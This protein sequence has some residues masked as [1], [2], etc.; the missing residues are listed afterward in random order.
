MTKSSRKD[1]SDG[2]ADD[3]AIKVGVVHH[4]GRQASLTYRYRGRRAQQKRRESER[5]VR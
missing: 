3:A 4:E 2:L 1:V 5:G